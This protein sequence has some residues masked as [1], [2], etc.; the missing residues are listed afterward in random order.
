[1]NLKTIRLERG[2][3]Q[4]QLAELTGLSQPAIAKIETGVNDIQNVS[5]AV[6]LKLSTALDCTIEELLK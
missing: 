1:M 3:T 5:G 6:L 2:L 4:K